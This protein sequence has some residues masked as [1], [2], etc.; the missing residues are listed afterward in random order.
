MLFDIFFLIYRHEAK[1]ID[2]FVKDIWSKLPNTISNENEHLVGMESR[3]E[4]VTLLL[5]VESDA[6]R[7][8]GIWGLGGIGKTTLAKAVL[9]RMKNRFQAACFLKEFGEESKRHGL[10]HL[11]KQLVNDLK[12]NNDCDGDKIIRR[13]RFKSV[14]LIL[15]NI[16][17]VDDID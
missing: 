14:L 2:I 7:I 8:V 16:H 5:D 3:I 17:D 13:L 11:E 4:K 12:I 15:D 10:R 1:C 6:V 9:R